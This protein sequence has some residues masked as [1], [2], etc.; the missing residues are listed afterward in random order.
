MS[1][2][3]RHAKCDGLSPVLPNDVIATWEKDQNQA[4]HAPDQAPL[5]CATNKYLGMRLDYRL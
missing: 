1:R 4:G 3:A 2:E 5:A